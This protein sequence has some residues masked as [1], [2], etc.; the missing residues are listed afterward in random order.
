M[1]LKVRL[2]LGAAVP[3]AFALPA[4]AQVTISTETTS[5]VATSTANNGAASDVEITSAGSVTLTD[6]PNSTAVTID[7]PNSVTNAGTISVV[8]SDNSTGVR[9]V[10]GAGGSFSTSGAIRRGLSMSRV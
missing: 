4:Y 1:S 6:D 3:L 7:S 8:N 9:I 5:P 2:L 10:P